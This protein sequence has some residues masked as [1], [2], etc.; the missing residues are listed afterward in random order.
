MESQRTFL[1][2]GLML[3]SFL[4]FQEWN[5]DYNAPKADPSATT[6]TQQANSPESDDFIPSSSDS[7]LPA[8]ATLAKRSVIE[9][10]TDVFKV[11]ID[12]KGG[13][14][15]EADLLQYEEVK[16]EETP[17]MLLGEFDGNQYFSQSG[18]IGLNGPDASANGRPTYQAPQKAY[19]LSGD[20]LRVPL[21]YVDSNGVSFTKTY[22]FKKGQYDVELEYKINNATS[23]PVQVQLYTQIKRTVQEKGSLVDQNYLGSAFG[24]DEE[25][26]EKYS[27]SDMADKNLNKNTQGGYVAFIQH[28]FVSAWVP[29]QDETHTIYSLIT[30][31][32]AAIIGSKAEPVSIQ[33]GSEQTLSAIYYMGPKESDILEAIH[34]D[35]DLTVDYG[36]LWF[37]SQPLFVLLK[38]LHSI[39]GNWGVAIIAIT[40][41]VKSLMYPLTKAQY[42]SMAKMRALQ[43]KMAAL[44]EKYGDDRQ[45]FGQATMEMYKKEKVNPMGGCF[46]ILLQMPIFLALF[47]VF[48]ESTE[49]RHAEFVLWLTDLSA[50]DPYYV[51][52]ILFGASMFVTQKLQPMTVT[53]PMQQKMMT[54]MPVI[55]SVFFL[56]FP[57]GLVLYWLVSNLISIVQMLIIYRGMEKKGIKVRG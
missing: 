3:V 20:E 47:Y 57:S 8:S 39:L 41:I 7:G 55:F 14:I 13:D 1:L 17:F 12:T 15:V 53:D 28:Y 42:T 22:V 51:L 40:I 43:P 19:T 6:Q 29:K 27:F 30:K 32:N 34:P 48:L 23:A 5:N 31:S 52:P 4:L 38:W 45:K 33:A 49:L 44:K 37:I 54:F 26:Y 9:I 25:P 24:T 2:I 36:W 21:T 50:Q 16:G 10:T 11:K 35:L 56:W 18:L 46:P